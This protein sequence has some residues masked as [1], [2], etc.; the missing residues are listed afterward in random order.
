MA[1]RGEELT[2][3][4]AYGRLAPW[5]RDEVAN[6]RLHAATK[7]RPIDRFQQELPQLRPL[8]AL[9]FNTEE[10]LP[11]VV[12]SHA[13]VGYDGNRY[14]V[15]PALVR[16]PVTLRANAAEVWIV[17]EGREVTRH[18]RC[19]ERGQLIVPPEDRLAALKLRRR[20]QAGQCEEEFDALGP[21]AREFH[22]KLLSMPVKT[23][24]HLRR[25]LGLVAS[26]LG[27]P[28]VFFFDRV[29]QGALD[30]A[31]SSA[32]LGALIVFEPSGIGNPKLFREA[33]SLSHVIKYSHERLRDIADLE[34]RQ[35]DHAGV[36]L[37]IETLGADGLRYR[38]RL[39]KVAVKGWPQVSAL[40]PLAFKDAAGAGDWC[41]AGILSRLA[42]GGL[43]G[44]RR[45]SSEKLQDALR[46]DRHWP[47]GTVVSRGLVAACTTSIGGRSND[48]W[49]RS[50]AAR[51]RHPPRPLP[52]SRSLSNS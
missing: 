44:F 42:R 21:L 31:K 15:P 35:S 8:P 9:P 32:D 5:W 25:L 3:W 17:D 7:Q 27:K 34:L 22:L 11:V 4:E 1:G 33:W 14:S 50:S 46:S 38:S 39:P 43:T 6:V 45:T 51:R 24:V 40:K 47:P 19:Y 41:T 28:Q 37:E 23:T 10:V 18:A 48:R 30:L 26:R 16:K 52:S 13:R 29:S 49:K 2:T 36:L 12:T 20:R